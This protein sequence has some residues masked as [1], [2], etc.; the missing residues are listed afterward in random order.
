ME[1][2][3]LEII[4]NGLKNIDKNNSNQLKNILKEYKLKLPKLL[5][6]VLI[7]QIETSLN[8]NHDN[9]KYPKYS[10]T[11]IRNIKMDIRHLKNIYS[12]NPELKIDLSL[13]KNQLLP[14]EKHICKK[15]IE[16]DLWKIK[17]ERFK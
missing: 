11:T 2:K 4:I 5:S 8:L 13:Y 17:Q 3:E 7:H 15:E 6:I 16:D 12:S 1:L 10:T 9:E 14:F